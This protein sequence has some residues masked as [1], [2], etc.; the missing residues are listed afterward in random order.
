[1]NLKQTKKLEKE[2][3]QKT[4]TGERQVLKH[5]LRHGTI[6]SMEA[7]TLYGMTR[8][9]ARIYDLREQ[10]HQIITTRVTKNEK[11]FGVYSLK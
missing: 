8:L 9:A 2:I 11:N 5:M 4:N 6:S 10:G 1:M 7:F 3:M